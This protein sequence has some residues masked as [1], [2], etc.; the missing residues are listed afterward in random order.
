MNSLARPFPT[1]SLEAGQ[2]RQKNPH[3]HYCHRSHHCQSEDG[4]QE[5]VHRGGREQNTVHFPDSYLL[6]SKAGLPQGPGIQPLLSRRGRSESREGVGNPPSHRVLAKIYCYHRRD[7][8]ENPLSWG[9]HRKLNSLP[10][11]L[12]GTHLGL[13]LLN[14]SKSAFTLAHFLNWDNI[15]IAQS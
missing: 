1:E 12:T 13:L 11:T 10:P 8:S 4:P 7:T 15:C 6:Q 14:H 3:N 9:K 2:G 5:V